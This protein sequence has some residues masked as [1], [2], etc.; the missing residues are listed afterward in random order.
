MEETSRKPPSNLRGTK[1][2]NKC[3]RRK[4]NDMKYLK[5]KSLGRL[6]KREALHDIEQQ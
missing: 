6:N 3:R 4:L 5:G 2:D 1:F